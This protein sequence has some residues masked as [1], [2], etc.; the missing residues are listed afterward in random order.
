MNFLIY[1]CAIIGGI[2]IYSLLYIFLIDPFIKY[3]KR[4]YLFYVLKKIRVAHYDSVF[5]YILGPSRVDIITRK[6]FKKLY[7]YEA[8]FKD[9]S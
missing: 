6:E 5:C 4:L 8:E 7:G 1:I 9:C 2:C 3:L